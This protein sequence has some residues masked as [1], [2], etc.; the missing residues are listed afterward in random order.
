MLVCCPL[1]FILPNNRQQHKKIC[2]FYL[3]KNDNK[4]KNLKPNLTKNSFFNVF[5]KNYVKFKLVCWRV[6]ISF[7]LP[8]PSGT[9]KTEKHHLHPRIKEPVKSVLSIWNLSRWIPQSWKHESPG[10][11]SLGKPAWHIILY[12]MCLDT[13]YESVSC[14]LGMRMEGF[15]FKYL[16]TFKA[17]GASAQVA[18]SFRGNMSV[19]R[20]LLTS[21]VKQTIWNPAERPKLFQRNAFDLF[22][23]R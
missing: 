23:Q 1:L 16:H 17:A 20:D 9:E 12:I 19:G 22:S 21:K 8:H 18:L 14:L 5:W 2:T 6:N 10:K 3:N 11:K 13:K 7:L 15:L 4:A